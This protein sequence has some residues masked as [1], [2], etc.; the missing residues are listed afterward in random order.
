MLFNKNTASYIINTHFIMEMT[1]KLKPF[2]LEASKAGAPVMTRDGRPVRI[3][4]FDVEGA[5]YPVVAAVKTLDGKR[6]AIQMYTE[7]G[8]YSYVVAKHDYDLVMARVKHRAWVN[9]YKSEQY[10]IVDTFDTEE[11]AIK[12]GEKFSTYITT[13]LVEWEE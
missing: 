3:L 12:Y 8:E 2:D 13:V 5:R 10:H 4:A 1:K 7:S 9:V 6:E 11:E